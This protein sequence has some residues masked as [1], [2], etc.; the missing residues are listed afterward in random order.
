MATTAKKYHYFCYKGG[1]GVG[2][3]QNRVDTKTLQTVTNNDISFDKVVAHEFSKK[4][5]EFVADRK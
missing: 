5:T 3:Q 1:G 2:G 4:T